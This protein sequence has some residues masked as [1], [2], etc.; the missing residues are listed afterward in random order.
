MQDAG[1]DVSLALGVGG[2]GRRQVEDREECV[3]RGEECVRR[4]EVTTVGLWLDCSW[5]V[6]G[7]RLDCAW[8][9]LR[10][11]LDCS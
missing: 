6:L 8:T 4:G 11:R 3:R 1:N 10:L 2:R 7:L 9:A 5:T